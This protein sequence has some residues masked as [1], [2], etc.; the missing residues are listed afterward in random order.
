MKN[1][2]LNVWHPRHAATA[3]VAL[4]CAV[5]LFSP[6]PSQGA[7]LLA[8]WLL[9]EFVPPYADAGPFGIPLASDAAT[10][11]PPSGAG[12]EGLAPLLQFEDPP[13][14]SSRLYADHSLLQSDSFGF[15]LWARPVYLNGGDRLLSKEMAFN[16]SV[17]AYSRTAW[18]VGLLP[19]NGS[20]Y[21]PVELIVRGSDRG[22]SDFHG[23]AVSAAVIP[24]QIDADD[25][26][27]IAGGYDS[28]TGDL[29]LYV[30]GVKTTSGNSS[31][32]A[33]N[34][35]GGPVALGTARNG[36][37]FVAFAGTM[38]AEDLQIYDAPLSD[39]EAAFLFGNP[40]SSVPGDFYIVS[41][42]IDGSSEDHA[43]SF[44]SVSGEDYVVEATTDLTG[45]ADVLDATADTPLERDADTANPIIG[46]GIEGD[47]P[48]VTWVEGSTASRLYSDDEA[49]QN[50]SFGF[51][52]WV[53]PA[54]LNPFDSLITKEMS[55]DDSVPLYSRMSWQ[56]H[57]LDNNGSDA[58]QIQLIVRG[59]D[60]TVGDFFGTAI[61][62]ATVPLFSASPQWYHVAG[63]YNAATGDL[64]LYVNG[65]ETISGNSSSGAANS[66]GGAFAVG[67][68]RNG[69]DF[70]AFGGIAYVDDIQLFD[71][72]PT[73]DEVDALISYPGEL[74]PD[75]SHLVAR[76][77]GNG[78]Q[79]PYSDVS[80]SHKISTL[81]ITDQMLDDVFGPSSR[82]H[83]FFRLSR[84]SEWE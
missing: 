26:I 73:A 72:P 79:P 66:D 22:V 41:A 75:T 3:G 39:E 69:A 21:A 38:F 82:S 76:W 64:R 19:D 77:L 84:K 32:G 46:A 57:L 78:S 70:V 29:T 49:L 67:S 12:I 51:S 80:G 30:N 4:A 55:F 13:G 53:K 2:N 34:S 17:P 7:E 61:S 28:A 74:G 15:S 36:G 27:H 11:T 48:Q 35:D 43:L 1:C 65:E 62:S 8:H 59:D 10:A 58:A 60:R 16:D 83:V 81:T 5:L 71:G 6:L 68:A 24:L 45:F 33:L 54:Y 18:T 44:E 47:A 40:A 14:V 23:N 52:F 25:W 37:D 9:N 20:G 31:P 56:V 50:N 42:G 63:G